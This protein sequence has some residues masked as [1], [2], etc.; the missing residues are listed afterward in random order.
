MS[1]TCAGSAIKR[2]LDIARPLGTRVSVVT[3]NDGKT[4]AEVA[5]RFADY[6]AEGAI[7]VHTGEQADGS[8][9]EPQVV[10]ANGVASMNQILGKSFGTEDALLE[11]MEGAKTEWAL[12]VFEAKGKLTMPQYVLDA[13]R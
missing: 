9:L 4:P 12:K 6:T 7:T 2:F 1:S 13:I 10:H 5:A 11:Y 8:T 3:D